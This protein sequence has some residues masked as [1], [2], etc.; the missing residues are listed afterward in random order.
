MP[1]RGVADGVCVWYQED[2][3]RGRRQIL[4]GQILVTVDMVFGASRPTPSGPR[5]VF[6]YGVS[7][8]RTCG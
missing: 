1:L 3:S 5:G 4:V 7:I 2:D 8:A 6:D